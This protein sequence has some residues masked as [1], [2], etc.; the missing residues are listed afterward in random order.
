MVQVT[1]KYYFL[2]RATQL[3]I[4]TSVGMYDAHVQWFIIQS[5]LGTL[6]GEFGADTAI[7]HNFHTNLGT[8]VIINNEISHGVD[9]DA[10]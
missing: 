3:I 4:L 6:S 10:P 7:A 9:N 2:T 8:T 5:I 1:N